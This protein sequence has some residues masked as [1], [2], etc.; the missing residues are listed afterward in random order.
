MNIFIALL[1]ILSFIPNFN[2]A[3]AGIVD[4]RFSVNINNGDVR[5]LMQL[6]A[7]KSGLTLNMDVDPGVK[8]SVNESSTTAKQ[9]LEKVTSDQQLDYEIHGNQL[10]VTKRRLIGTVPGNA[11]LVTLKFANAT[12]LAAKFDRVLSPD[13]KVVVD[14][15]GNNLIYIGSPAGFA[16]FRSLT[17][18]FDK[19]PEQILIEARIV[20]TSDSFLRE[21]NTSL[22]L[23]NE[24][25]TKSITT[26]TPLPASTN[27]SLR[28]MVGSIGGRVLDLR[29]NAA[30]TKGQARIISRPKVMTLNNRLAKIESGLSFNVRTLVSGAAGTNNGSQNPAIPGVGTIAGTSFT[31]Q[32]TSVNAGLTLAILPSILNVDRI[33]MNVEINNSQPDQGLAVDGIPG[34]R[35][36][37]ATTSVI[38]RDGHTAIIAGLIKQENS[39]SKSQV[40][41]LGDIPLIG[42]LFR[43]TSVSNR[44]NEL[45][46]FLTATID[47]EE[48]RN[49]AATPVAA[50]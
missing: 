38:V 10:T 49:P 41:F 46:I 12:E 25:G 8:I 27:F 31:S 44:N 45:V 30:E 39:D 35:N 33:R 6:V 50:P 14:E 15:R 5:T 21:L 48:E 37:S 20:E 19:S 17:A 47:R 43:S 1:I 42:L 22:G 2:G 16:K 7:A 3:L 36:N 18:F 24:S 28:D 11:Q 13:E 34:I 29:L 32:L 26:T 40:P 9:I 4:D 23:Q